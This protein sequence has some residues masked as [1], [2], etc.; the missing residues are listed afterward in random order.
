LT[1]GHPLTTLPA[2]NWPFFSRSAQLHRQ[3]A[4]SVTEMF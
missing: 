1:V 2:C 3:K 4:T